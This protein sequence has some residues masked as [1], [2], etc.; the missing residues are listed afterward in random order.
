MKYNTSL[1]DQV[2]DKLQDEILD[3]TIERDSIITEN[4][5]AEKLGISR[6]PVREAFKMLERERLIEDA[7][8]GMR[9]LGISDSDM[10]DA[11]YIREKLEGR[12]GEL[13]AKRITDEQIKKLQ[14]ILEFQEF[15][16]NKN[17]PKNKRKTHGK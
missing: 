13:A 6:T 5:V 8:K 2:F 15:Y 10:E 14:E 9:V 7:G 11:Y 3:G 16:V 12:A 1:S 17:N 4:Q